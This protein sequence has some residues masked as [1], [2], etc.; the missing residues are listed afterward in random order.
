M[1]QS[2]SPPASGTE[3]A[4]APLSVATDL[5]LTIDGVDAAVESTG[6]RLSLQ[7]R[8]VSDALRAARR[9]PA[10]ADALSATLTA[11][12]LTAE[13]RVRDR[14]VVVVGTDARPGPLSRLLGAAPAE[15]RPGALVGAAAS[16]AVVAADRLLG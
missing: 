5:D 4:V 16:V 8:S 10:G 7:F 3:P 14:I 12:D 6:R 1:G 2:Q 11:A 13:V 15:V 9:R